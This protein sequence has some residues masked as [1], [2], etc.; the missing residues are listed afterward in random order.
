MKRTLFLI[1]VFSSISFGYGV[2]TVQYRIFPYD[3]VVLAKNTILGKSDSRSAR[4]LHKK[5][6]YDE[7]GRCCYDIVFIGDSITEDANW[8]DIFPNYRVANRGIGGDTSDGI[9][10]RMD[11]I[12]STKASK[13]FIMVGVN[14]LTKRTSIDVIFN[15]YQ[16]IIAPLL[17]NDISVYL[18]STLYVATRGEEFNLSIAMLNQKLE[19]F[20]AQN[21]KLAYINL[22]KTLSVNRALKSDFSEDGVHLNAQG[23]KAWKDAIKDYL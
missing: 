1:L 20:A 2:A 12:I 3:L 6:I 17:A 4:Y 22:N 5:S 23:Y 19:S 13:A 8:E 16:Q 21:N 14:D 7:F 15:N 9:V 10:E 11:S 18:Q